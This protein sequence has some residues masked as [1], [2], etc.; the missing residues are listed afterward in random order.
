[1]PTSVSLFIGC[2]NDLYFPRVGV[3]VTK[4]LER[5]G[6]RVDFP[7]QQ[8][9]C[10]APLFEDGYQPQ[11]KGLARRFVDVFKHSTYVVTPSP[12]CCAMV[13]EN[14][15]RLL[16]D[17]PASE[18]TMWQVAGRTYEFVEFLTTVLKV[19]LSKLSLPAQ[20]SVTYHPACQQ[21]AMGVGDETPRVIRQLQHARLQLPEKADVCCGAG[22]GLPENQ[23]MISTTMRDEKIAAIRAVKADVTICNEAVCALRLPTV[24]PKHVA[25]LL[26]EAMGID[27]NSF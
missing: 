12:R 5:F 15:T 16:V 1:M 3:A 22:G 9:C 24:K 25:E 8:T 2:L 7:D 10:G 19:D 21:R 17:D 6:C 27:S 20:T 18:E 23:P 14:Y 13:R 4:I 11:A 26:A